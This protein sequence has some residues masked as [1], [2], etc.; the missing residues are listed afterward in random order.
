MLPFLL[1]DHKLP[2]TSA[3]KELLFK[4]TA[5]FAIVEFLLSHGTF[6]LDSFERI[7]RSR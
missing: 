1:D 6:S 7:V 5:S 3:T 2:I 4:G